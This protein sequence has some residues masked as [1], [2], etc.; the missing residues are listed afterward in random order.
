[1]TKIRYDELQ[2]GDVILFRGAKVKVLTVD[3]KPETENHP[4]EK[5]VSFTLAPADA[6]A[7]KFLGKFYSRGRYSSIGSRSIYLVERGA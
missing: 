3:I 6:E 2:A 4:G 1:M 5:Y 7:E